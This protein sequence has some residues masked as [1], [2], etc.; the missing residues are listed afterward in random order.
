[1]RLNS[2]NMEQNGSW[3]LLTI[4]SGLGSGLSIGGSIPQLVPEKTNDPMIE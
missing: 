4:C 1:M 3:K 2:L